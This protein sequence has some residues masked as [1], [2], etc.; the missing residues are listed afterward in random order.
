[1]PRDPAEQIAAAIVAAPA[2][3]DR[4][5]HG[6]W[7]V[8]GAVHTGPRTVDVDIGGTTVPGIP[9]LDPYVPTE[10]HRVLVLLQNGDPVVIGGR[11]P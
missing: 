9:Y 8:A 3:S 1:M 10:G 4:G 11:A 5:A 7:G 2:L 6:R